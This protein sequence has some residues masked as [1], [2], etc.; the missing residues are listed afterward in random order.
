M[1]TYSYQLHRQGRNSRTAV[2]RHRHASRSL[3]ESRQTHGN[4]IAYAVV[5][6]F[7]A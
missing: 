3:Q 6:H 1:V 7:V 4:R 5:P 2:S